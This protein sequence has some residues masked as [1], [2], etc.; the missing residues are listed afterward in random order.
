MFMQRTN[1]M[2]NDLNIARKIPLIKRPL[3]DCINTARRVEGRPDARKRLKDP[4][5]GTIAGVVGMARKVPGVVS[6]ETRFSAM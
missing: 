6:M 5:L 1:R 4:R 3:L 2:P